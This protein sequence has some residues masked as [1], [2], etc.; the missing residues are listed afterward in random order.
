MLLPILV[1]LVGVSPIDVYSEDPP[2]TANLNH[3]HY[4][5]DELVILSVTVIN[6]DSPQQLKPNLPPLDGLSIVNF[7]IATSVRDIN[8]RIQTEVIYTYQLQPRRT[9]DI[10]IPPIAV[11]VDGR[12]YRTSP[13]S[14][15]VSQG[16]APAP[17]PGNAVPP[18]SIIPP[19]DLQGQDFFVESVVDVSSPYIGQQLVYTFRFYQAIKLYQKPQYDMPI[20]NG[21]DTIGLPVQEYNVEA[22]GRAYLVTEIRTAL[23]PKHDGSIVIGPARLTFPGNFFE[24]PIELLT[25]PVNLRVLPLPDNPPP[26]FN[27]AVG[28][29]QMEA[30]FS[31]QVAIANQPSTYQVAISGNGNIHVLPQPIWPILNGWRIFDSDSSLTT[32]MNGDVMTGTRIFELV[33]ASDNLGDFNIP[34]TKLVYFDP[35]AAEYRSISTKSIP[36]R[37]IPAPTPNPKTA[38]AV[39]ISA[40]PTATPVIFNSSSPFDN[41]PVNQILPDSLEMSFP[42]ALSIAA[43]LF[44]IVCSAI[45]VAAVTGAGA[46]WMWHQKKHQVEKE[47]TVLKQ[48]SKTM[49]PTLAAALAQNNDNYKAASEAM[50]VY[51]SQALSV[52]ATGLTRTELANHLHRRGV[53]KSLINKIKDYLAR[54]EMG[55]FGPKSDDNG[56]ELLARTDE[57]LFEL[58]KAFDE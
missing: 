21:L 40:L 13:L 32:G 53:P 31:P 55:R 45:P 28:Q 12:T 47:A 44:W 23:F 2:I 11:D 38:T 9:G 34:P 57:L 16:S 52:S 50:N 48:P 6:D 25:N 24:D 39:A 7:D 20:F 29:Y 5:T 22:D 15:T 30:S 27:G 26:G 41:Q 36:G 4:T 46:V 54:S 8:G 33:I 19:T 1:L 56:W 3:D 49:H 35:V 17:S 37:I 14:L 10:T 42:M 18:V 51:L 43:I 58:D